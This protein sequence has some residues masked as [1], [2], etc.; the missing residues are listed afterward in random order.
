MRYTLRYALITG[1]A[2]ICLLST[3]VRA[4][5]VAVAVTTVNVTAESDGIRAVAQGEVT[6]MRLEVI[7]ASG[8]IIFETASL[9][10]EVL[11]WNRLDAQGLP[12]RDG[13]Y[14]CVV[15]FKDSSGKIRKRIEQVTV[16]EDAPQATSEPR[17]TQAASDP[18]GVIHDSTLN[19]DGTALSPLRVAMPLL[20]DLAGNINFGVPGH[21]V[22]LPSDTP[23]Q[24]GEDGVG[25]G[26]LRFPT[27]KAGKEFSFDVTEQFPGDP[28]LSI[29]Y[30]SYAGVQINRQ[31]PALFHTIEGDYH[32]PVNG[33][34]YFEMNTH[35]I[36]EDG[37]EHRLQAFSARRA[38]VGQVSWMWAGDDFR[39]L[40]TG[41]LDK[42]GH[43]RPFF[44]ANVPAQQGMM[45][46]SWGIGVSSPTGLTPTNRVVVPNG[47]YYAGLNNTGTGSMSLIGVG[48]TNRILIAPGGQQTS[49]GGKLVVGKD[50]AATA[51]LTIYGAPGSREGQTIR[52]GQST[53]TD[54][55]IY[56]DPLTG[57]LVFTGSQGAAYAGYKF[58]AQVEAR[59]ISLGGGITW[60]RGAAA[61]TGSCLTGSLYSNTRGGVN[62][63][64]YVCAAGAWIAK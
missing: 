56:R 55:S 25:R 16:K 54:Y 46:G 4:Q 57:K 52:L 39:F 8:E 20:T 63:T 34:H 12:V 53:T 28:V 64:L 50:Q 6:E 30:N 37:V 24:L 38:D 41:E 15:T 7:D 48:S 45:Q 40:P 5:D 32:N 29:G 9:P 3:N 27:I 14:A 31:E 2:V 59:S 21:R 11:E 47:S 51:A 36:S 62:N 58:D 10:A 33:A 43:A 26:T 35:V 23:L 19:G 13:Q 1:Y 44:W 17:I 61:P 42:T 18:N 60:T 22:R 49:I